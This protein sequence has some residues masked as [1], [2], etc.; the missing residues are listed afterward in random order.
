MFT[1]MEIVML[2]AVVIYGMPKKTKESLKNYLK[3]LCTYTRVITKN[4]KNG[5]TVLIN[6]DI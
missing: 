4:R 6:S 2:S 1:I 3:R 5:Y